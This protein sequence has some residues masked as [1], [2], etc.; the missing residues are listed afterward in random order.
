MFDPFLAVVDPIGEGRV[1]MNVGFTFCYSF[2]FSMANERVV[3]PVSSWPGEAPLE[4]ES[5]F[6]EGG[7]SEIPFG[8]VGK[9]EDWEV[10]LPSTSDRVCLE[11]E[12]WC[13]ST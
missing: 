1:D 3:A 10:L 11:Y 13:V 6:S 4:T 2:K 12:N 5:V 8:S 9:S 7:T